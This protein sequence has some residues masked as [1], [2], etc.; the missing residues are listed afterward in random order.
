MPIRESAGPD[1][2]IGTADDACAGAGQCCVGGACNTSTVVKGF[3]RQI[4]IT[5][6]NDPQRPSPP[7]PIMMRRIE[8]AIFYQAGNAIRRE[9]V[10]TVI[11]SYQ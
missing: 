1:G 6:I 2:I 11:T 4:T 10:A 8:I 5:D 3:Q 9:E 7:W